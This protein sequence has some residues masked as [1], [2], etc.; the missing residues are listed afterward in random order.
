MIVGLVLGTS[1][2]RS[3]EMFLMCALCEMSFIKF[4]F[5]YKYFDCVLL[6]FIEYV[7]CL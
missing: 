7:C 4:E 5:D 1:P 2:D 6:C 3:F